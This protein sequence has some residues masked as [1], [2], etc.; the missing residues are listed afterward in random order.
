[1]VLSLGFSGN[2]ESEN[3][4]LISKKLFESNHKKLGAGFI[5]NTKVEN[6]QKIKNRYYRI[7]EKI[8]KENIRYL[9]PD[10][11]FALSSINIVEKILEK[12]KNFT[13][14]IV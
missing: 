9:H 4:N 14:T 5:S 7:E 6:Q 8:G 2:L 11:G 3:F 1:M 13:K 12:M 10:C